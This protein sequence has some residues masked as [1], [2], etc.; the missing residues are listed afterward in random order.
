MTERLYQIIGEIRVKSN[1]LIQQLDDE[2]TKSQTFQTEI[3]DL[4]EKL[5]AQ[6]EKEV[7]LLEEIAI[8][9]TDLNAIKSQIIEKPIS[10]L[11]KENEIDELVKEIE[12]CISQLK[13]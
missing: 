11:S 3:I 13:K 4:N 12:Y 1:R 6:K 5:H 10:T 9:Q 7:Q 2:Q 8:L